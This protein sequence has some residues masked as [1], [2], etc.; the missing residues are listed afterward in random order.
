MFAYRPLVAVCIRQGQFSPDYAAIADVLEEIDRLAELRYFTTQLVGGQ[1]GRTTEVAKEK[2]SNHNGVRRD[3]FLIE[4]IVAHVT[5]Y[6]KA[7]AAA[8]AQRRLVARFLDQDTSALTTLE[9]AL[10]RPVY[11]YLSE[12]LHNRQRGTEDPPFLCDRHMLY[13]RSV[14]PISATHRSCDILLEYFL[15]ALGWARR[16]LLTSCARLSTDCLSST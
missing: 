14:L 9:L 5:E 2:L 12:V 3:M 4:S 16:R 15:D 10:L 8:H 6:S 11:A 7:D 1:P 13:L